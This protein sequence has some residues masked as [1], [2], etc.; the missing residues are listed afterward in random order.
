MSKGIYS[1]S[2][3]MRGLLV[4]DSRLSGSDAHAAG[5]LDGWR[6][7]VLAVEALDCRAGISMDERR[8]KV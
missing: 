7:R 3:E 6:D 2:K 4:I 8:S 1:L 5:K